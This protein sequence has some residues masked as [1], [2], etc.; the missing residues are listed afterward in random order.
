MII[1]VDK[2]HTFGIMNKSTTSAQTRP[3]LYVNVKVMPPLKDDESFKYLGK[4]FHFSMN[5][6]KHKEKP[7]ETKSTALNIFDKL[8]SLFKQ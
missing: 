1:R 6:Q 3:K 2:C 4:D 8:P 5:N 7:L